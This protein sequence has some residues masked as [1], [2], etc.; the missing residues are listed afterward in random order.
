MKLL[1]VDGF[2]DHRHRALQYLVLEGW[3]ANGPLRPI[4][5]RDVRPT[6]GRCSVRPGLRAVEQRREILLEPL[7]VLLRGLPVDARCSIL[8]RAAVRLAQPLHVDVMRQRGQRH[9][10]LLL[11]QLCYP[12]EFR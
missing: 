6:H 11:R 10:S 1:L 5:L 3:N 8:A 7:R 2:Q 4:A 9:A 12:F